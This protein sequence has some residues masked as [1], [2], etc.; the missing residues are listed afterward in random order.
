VIDPVVVLALRA[1][2]AALFA[3]AALHKLRGF[4]E[5]RVA[6]ADYQ[7]VPWWTSGIAARALVAAECATAVL[8]LS[9][10]ARPTGF[11][12]AA[13]LLALYGAAIAV[14]LLR[15]RRDID[16]GCFGP[17]QRAPLGVGLVVRNA[18]LA[19]VALTGLL[20]TVDRP[21]GGVDAITAAALVLAL[22]LLHAAASQLIAN[23]P[24]LRSLRGPA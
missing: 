19:A 9:P 7:L 12:A 24:R 18:L 23:A 5:F 4:A 14:N 1:A 11:A 13:G 3:S 2:G 20:P 6:L 21:L 22:A 10:L 17:A 15:G 8:L 16:C